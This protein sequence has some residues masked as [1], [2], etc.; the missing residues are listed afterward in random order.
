MV[1]T[2]P[3]GTRYKNE[4]TYRNSIQGRQQKSADEGIEW[5][6]A[7]DGSWVAK[8]VQEGAKFT[9]E[10]TWA[11]KWL[12]G[13]IKRGIPK[14]PTRQVAGMTDIEQ[15]GQDILAD[16]ASGKTFR[17]PMT[18]EYYKGMRGELDREEEKGVGEL[19]RRSQ[20]S[21]MGASTP[22]FATEAEYRASMA[23]KRSSILGSLYESESARD[24]PYTRMAAVSSYGRLPREIKQE[25]DDAVYNAILQKLMFPYQTQ[26]G[27][28]GMLTG[29]MTQPDVTNYQII[30]KEPDNDPNITDWIT[31]IGSFF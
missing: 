6:Q 25:S 21:G 26:S 24:N 31:A 22:A 16:V 4:A 5:F 11:Q 20:L 19:R 17:D 29:L 7:P 13:L 18:S 8:S 27:V 15:Q 3:T 2:D 12:Q 10:A 9:K 30:G 1:W 23:A 14:F 28:A